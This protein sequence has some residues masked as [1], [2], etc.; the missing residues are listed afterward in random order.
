MVTRVGISEFPCK[1]ALT[2]RWL[3]ITEWDERE[4]TCKHS[5]PCMEMRRLIFV[6]F[7]ACVDPPLPCKQFSIGHQG[8]P[9]WVAHANT[10]L[11][12]GWRI[13]AGPLLIWLTFYDTNKIF[14]K[15]EKNYWMMQMG[16]L[17]TIIFFYLILIVY[18]PLGLWFFYF[19][20]RWG[21]KIPRSLLGCEIVL[22][23]YGYELKIVQMD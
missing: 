20:L 11:A 1:I 13:L 14:V 8:W 19:N 12:H 17:G 23:Q 15:C 7:C 4:K 2:H 10:C 18:K 16:K 6:S 22:V 21:T 5:S 9:R 3:V